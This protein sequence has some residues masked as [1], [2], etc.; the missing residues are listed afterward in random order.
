[1]S[2]VTPVVSASQRCA[3]LALA[4]LLGL[5]GA[6]ACS[7]TATLAAAGDAGSGADVAAGALVDAALDTAADAAPTDAPAK[8]DADVAAGSSS[9]NLL[10]FCQPWA[11]WACQRALQ[12]SCT[13][14][15]SGPPTQ[16]ICLPWM[17]DICLK[18]MAKIDGAL[19]AGMLAI[20]PARVPACITWLDQL[21]PLCV[22]AG[23]S[24][25]GPG[26]CAEWLHQP[27]LA[28]GKCQ[29]SDQLCPDGSG[30][31]DE[32]CGAVRLED[33]A[34]CKSASHCQSLQCDSQSKTCKPILKIGSPCKEGDH[35]PLLSQ[36]S[37]G[38]CAGLPKLG[39]ACTSSDTCGLLMTCSAGNCATGPKTCTPGQDCGGGGKCLGPVFNSCKAQ[40]AQGAPCVQDAQCKAALWCDPAA[41]QCAP[42]PAAGS[43]CANGVLCGP[44]LGC[45]SDTQLCAAL[46]KKGEPCAM[47]EFGPMLCG[48]GLVCQ[49]DAFVCADP[50]AE[51]AACNQHGNCS[52][53]AG[54]SPG[55]LVCAFGPT[56]STCVKRQPKGSKCEND[57][58]AAGLFC[59]FK[60]NSCAQVYATGQSCS[61][62][63]EC[64]LDGSCAPDDQGKLRCVPMPGAGG[65]CLMECAEGLFC[66]KGM[67]Q[68]TCQPPVCQLFYQLQ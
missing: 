34:P 6:T 27:V 64:G 32:K 67:T 10:D 4:L 21:L 52:P 51:G 30:C 59:D 31:V 39:D 14:P 1:M 8:A 26:P 63:N 41:G 57:I 19:Q 3:A 62:G 56:G 46:P 18:D 48:P 61:A 45:T 22:V 55:D 7:S 2:P 16:A 60:S 13:T 40:L 43:P 50:P 20:D 29:F 47:S 65:T 38:Y 42:R 54:K 25:L 9:K 66:D 11:A 35:C 58:C 23:K 17:T 12:C 53:S 5:A 68:G 15:K 36:C 33:G 44:G 49:T 37:A 28:G 24:A